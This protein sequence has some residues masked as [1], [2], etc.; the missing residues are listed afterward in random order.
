MLQDF[1]RKGKMYR[2]EVLLS[3]IVFLVALGSF[4]LG[5]LSVSEQR[6]PIRIIEPQEKES[7]STSVSASPSPRVS[8]QT[9]TAAVSAVMTK[10]SEEV[11]ASK[12][13]SVYHFPWC[14]GAQK[15]KEENKVIYASA[16]EAK[17]AGLRPAANCPG[18][19]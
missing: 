17:A 1:I 10:Q 16:V 14:A 12:N 6:E 11:I 18:L 8:P 5:R 13:G 9:Q 19:E 15:M 7:M 3:F 2:E 4:G